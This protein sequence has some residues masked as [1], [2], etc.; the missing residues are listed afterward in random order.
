LDL[1]RGWRFQPGDNLAFAAPAFDDRAWE[2]AA[3]GL[4]WQKQG[5]PKLG[6][7]AWY[8]L[9]FT[10]PNSLRGRDALKEGVKLALGR[11]GDCDQVFLNGQLAGSDGLD[12][13]TGSV[14]DPGFQGL[15]DSFRTLERVY[16]LPARDPRLRWGRE[17]VLAVR[18]R[19]TDYEGGF[20]SSGQS[21]TM[22]TAADLTALDAPTRPFAFQGQIPT[23]TFRLTNRA[24]GHALKGTLRIQA[25]GALTGRALLD[26]TFP[27]AL[28]P[29][30]SKALTFALPPLDEAAATTYSLRVGKGAWVDLAREACPYVLTP[31][32]PAAP[33]INGPTATAA[34]PGHPF[35]FAIPASGARPM[36]YDALGLPE[37]LSV[38]PGTGLIQGAVAKAGT[39]KVV[40]AAHNAEGEA[41][42]NLDIV[43][44]EALALTPPMGWNSW[45]SWG[46]AVTE[47]I[48]VASARTF[49]D[50]GLQDHGWS[51]VNIDDGWE[52]PENGGPG[53][54][55][56]GRILVNA[57][58]PDM[59]RLGTRLHQLGLKFG[60]Y[61]SP[62]PLTCGLHTG[63][64]QHELDD[65]KA[66]AAWGV[67]YLKYDW[68]SYGRI[69]KDKS[70]PE[71]VKPYRVMRE[72]LDQVDRDIVYSLCQY[73]MGK[74]WEW[75]GTVGAQLWRTTGDIEDTWESLRTIGFSQVENAPFAGPGHW[76]DP[77]MLVVGQVGWGPTLHPS[78]LTPDEQYTHIS[79]WCMLSAPLLI[80]CDLAALDPFTLNLLTNDE[81]LAVDQ[82]PLGRAATPR[83][84]QGD[85]QVWVKPLQ[86]GGSAVAAF[87]LG[88][89]PLACTLDLKALEIPGDARL[90]DL[91]RQKDLG[92]A[93]ELQVPPH[94]VVLLKA[95]R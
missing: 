89:K 37:G 24:Q 36:T 9:R 83:L 72:A 91:W 86:D 93:R 33:R 64:Y 71:L 17:N 18:V 76:N 2:P 40:L 35:L 30:A 78:R 45:N 55:P 62:G 20:L 16:T 50:K 34:R 53:R 46:L 32:A 81:V 94:G 7:M 84:K 13:P 43:V 28:P 31:P 92:G 8:R 51:Y 75:G 63:S 29:G 57:K 60:I 54:D 69:A 73:G 27:L 41:R 1:T 59:A 26:R 4:P 90:R 6:G 66:Y 44:G 23:K 22:A 67:D 85:L 10:L 77:D 3:T 82:D 95:S 48:V 38:D 70:L 74:V 49:I 14:P 61:S 56:S 21:L 80:G 79:L 65:A 39:Y 19:Q 5:H 87:N 58:F 88:E 47:E 15:Q 68:C 42:R 52:I 12:L 25:T 11:I